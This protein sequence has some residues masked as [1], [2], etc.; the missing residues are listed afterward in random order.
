MNKKRVLVYG[1]GPLGCLFAARLHQAGHDVRL[2]ARGH[3]LESLQAHG[4]RL[5]NFETGEISVENIQLGRQLT[6]D[7]QY[8][9]V[10]VIMRKN[11]ARDILPVLENNRHTPNILFFMNSFAGPDE[12]VQV[13]RAERVMLGF[14]SSAGSWRE[15]TLCFLGGGTSRTLTIP[16]G[17][18]DG[19]IKER[20]L[21]AAELLETMSG[22][23]VDIRVDMD[24]WLK[25]H[26][27]LLMPSLGP[28]LYAA[29][30]DRL[31]LANTPD[32][33]VLAVRAI[34]EGVAV[35]NAMQIPLTPTYFRRLN[36]LPEP[37]LVAFIRRIMQR[38]QMEVAMVGHAH[39]ARN[40]VLN[41]ADE[42]IA[43]ARQYGVKTPA[44]DTLYPYL[45]VDHPLFPEG[46]AEIPMNWRSIYATALLAAAAAVG[47]L[48]Y[49]LWG[50]R[51]K[52]N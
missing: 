33:L 26:T 43:A 18:V 4:L 3:R 5:E 52:I 30:I 24:A 37:L 36:L 23:Q 46:H 27:V 40:E 49:C 39:A 42:V 6:P 19:T 50:Q 10:L 12:F 44:I 51:R 21:A 7:D 15:D 38:A 16:I 34:R 29:G 20:T 14:P 35:L 47:I 31:R 17:E 9:F 45:Q 41:L 48:G 22:Y 32:L 8:D 25:T 13:L 1:A 11:Y 2:L 28:A